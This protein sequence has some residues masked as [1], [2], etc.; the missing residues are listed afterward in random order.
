V[1][2]ALKEEFMYGGVYVDRHDV[3]VCGLLYGAR[4]VAV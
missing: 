4:I 2:T 1:V 3:V